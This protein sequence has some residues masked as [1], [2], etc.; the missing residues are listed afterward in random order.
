MY[1]VVVQ[2]IDVAIGLP[3]RQ[4]SPINQDTPV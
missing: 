3:T 2:I 4:I 1:G